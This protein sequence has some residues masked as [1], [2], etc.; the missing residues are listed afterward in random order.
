MFLPLTDK[1]INGMEK[2]KRFD[3]QRKNIYRCGINQMLNMLLNIV[4]FFVIGLVFNKI[5][6]TIIFTFAYIP[7]RSYAGGFHASTPFRCWIISAIMLICVFSFMIL[8]NPNVYVYDTMGLSA[9]FLIILLSPVEDKNKPLDAIEIKVYKKRTIIILF[10][11]IASVIVLK[12][13]NL[14]ELSSMIEITFVTL[15]IMI[16][17]G[18]IK[19]MVYD[20]TEKREQ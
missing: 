5:V 9:V 6:E 13:S 12:L 14:T 1:I 19:N 17:F 16:I 4:T 8:V 20:K 7:L 10:T 18:I 3:P 11:E 2:R 15:T